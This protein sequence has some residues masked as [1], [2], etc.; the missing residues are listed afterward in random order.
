MTAVIRIYLYDKGSKWLSFLLARM[1]NFANL[2]RTI[3][4]PLILAL[5]EACLRLQIVCLFSPSLQE[6]LESDFFL[7]VSYV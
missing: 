5:R 2:G 1:K 7:T 3:F 4:E 6:K